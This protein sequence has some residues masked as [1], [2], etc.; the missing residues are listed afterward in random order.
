MKKL[1]VLLLFFPW[2]LSAQNLVPN[3]GFEEVGRLG[4]YWTSNNQQ[5]DNCIKH[6]SSP[7]QGSPDVLHTKL[8][9]LIKPNRPHLEI[10]GH[11]PRTGDYFVGIKT[12]GCAT[13]T[14][15]CKEYIQTHLLRPMLP[16]K[17]YYIEF[18]IN[19]AKTS[20]RVN[21][22]GLALSENKISEPLQLGLYYF[23]PVLQAE[24]ILDSNPNDWIKISDT[25]TV[26]RA[27]EYLLIGSFAPDDFISVDTSQTLLRYSYY[28]I[29][30]V[31]VQPLDPSFSEDI[32]QEGV[33]VTLQNVFF[34]LNK[35]SLSNESAFELD[36][37]FQLLKQNSKLKIRI[38]GHTDNTGNDEQNLQLSRERAD[39]VLDYL[40]EKGIKS[41][42]LTA[43]G[44]GSTQPVSDNETEEGRQKNRRVEFIPVEI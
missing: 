17:R 39:T 23:Q 26:E 22:I 11:K 18:W 21:K 15:H 32:F 7:N 24:E 10:I 34:E 36:Y 16:G 9:P 13:K 38:V 28:F 35:A 40:V 44:M 4:K 30:D 5:F 6:W 19:P 14:L 8:V 37:L 43:V 42:R 41:S 20:P 25:I 27:M 29:D 31:L 1:T 3:P 12:Y 2:F 33:P